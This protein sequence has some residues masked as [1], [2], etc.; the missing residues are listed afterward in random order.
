MRQKFAD[1][2][3]QAGADW[4]YIFRNELRNIFKD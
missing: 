3:K 1:Y 4:N 2:W